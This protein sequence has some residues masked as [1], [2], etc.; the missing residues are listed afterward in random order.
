MNNLLNHSNENTLIHEVVIFFHT[1][2]RPF[3]IWFLSINPIW[4]TF[5]QYLVLAFNELQNSGVF[6][7]FYSDPFGLSWKLSGF[8][9]SNLN[10]VVS[11]VFNFLLVKF[12]N[13]RKSCSLQPLHIVHK[14]M[15]FPAWCSVCTE[16]WPQPHRTPLGWIVTLTACIYSSKKQFLT[17]LILW[18]MNESKPIHTIFQTVI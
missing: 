18:W 5:L 12:Y 15:L 10:S 4:I 8:L 3:I 17:S 14:D 2:I 11:E 13:G 9:N 1:K 6:L 16:P 7:L